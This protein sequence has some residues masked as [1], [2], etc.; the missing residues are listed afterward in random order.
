MCVSSQGN[1]PQLSSGY[2]GAQA[3]K[4]LRQKDAAERGDGNGTS[5]SAASSPPPDC[6]VCSVQ[7]KRPYQE[8]QYAICPSLHDTAAVDAPETH[9]FAVFDGHAGGRCSKHISSSFP[10]NLATDESFKSKLAVALKKTFARTNDQFLELAQ[11]SRMNDGSTGVCLAIRDN[12][13][14]VANVGDSRAVLVTGG[15]AIALTKD[16]KPSS[17]EE[18]RRIS[19][20]GGVITYNTGIPRV[21]GV[22]AVSRAF[23]NFGIHQYIRADPDLVSREITAE[24][25][26]VVLA[27][28]GLWD[29]YRNAEVAEICCAMSN[30]GCKLQ[31][32]V[33][34]LVQNAIMKGSMDNVTCVLVRLN[35]DGSGAPRISSSPLLMGGDA[36]DDSE[37]AEMTTTGGGLQRGYGARS[38]HMYQQ[39]QRRPSQG[40]LDGSTPYEADEAFRR[41]M[42][43]MMQDDDQAA[44]SSSSSNSS[45]GARKMLGRSLST[46]RIGGRAT[47]GQDLG[48]TMN[49]SAEMSALFRSSSGEQSGGGDGDAG[50][51]TSSH[52]GHGHGSGGTATTG[53]ISS[54]FYSSSSAAAPYTKTIVRASP[55]A[56]DMMSGG[57]NS[58]S[59]S[60]YAAASS[61]GGA[62]AGYDLQSASY[63]YRSVNTSG[64]PLTSSGAAE[65]GY[66]GGLGGGGGSGGGGVGKGGK[67]LL[68]VSTSRSSATETVTSL[69]LMRPSSSSSSAI[70]TGVGAGATKSLSTRLQES[71]EPKITLPTGPLLKTMAPSPVATQGKGS[72]FAQRILATNGGAGGVGSGGGVSDSAPPPHSPITTVRKRIVMPGL[73]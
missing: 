42:K 46:N 4:L 1:L 15:R 18:Q 51:S 25:S 2:S 73:Y 16:H 20:F 28:D 14:H 24:D 68:S 30:Q 60:R 37:E 61:A 45:S 13:F 33:D 38:N 66:S 54:G 70:T 48:V 27:S 50:S 57:S 19:S 17:P 34:H 41:A 64:R 9:F 58:S 3:T 62:D 59:M 49:N 22:L 29:V 40:G 7:G 31:R 53:G 65:L 43:E 71:S 44:G 47:T 39:Q 55:S 11:K 56:S 72:A 23:G 12:K 5:S 63:K 36:Q 21:Q 10:A 52:I 8:D 32:I 67:K 69:T 35:G 6:A 26:F